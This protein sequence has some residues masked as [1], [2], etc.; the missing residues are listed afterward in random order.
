MFL[1]FDWWT[2]GVS[3]FR[4]GLTQSAQESKGHATSFKLGDILVKIGKTNVLGYNLRELRQLVRKIPTGTQLQIIVYR[5]YKEISDHW[6]AAARALSTQSVQLSSEEG[7]F[8]LSSSSTD[9]DDQTPRARFKNFRPLSLFWHDR[10]ISIPPV[11]RTWH[12]SRKNRNVLI[13][14]SHVDC[15]IVL[16]RKFEDDQVVDEG[17]VEAAPLYAPWLE[18]PDTVSSSSSSSSSSDLQWIR[19]LQSSDFNLPQGDTQHE[20]TTGKSAHVVPGQSQLQ[21]LAME[22]GE[23]SSISTLDPESATLPSIEFFLQHFHSV[24][25]GTYAQSTDTHSSVVTSGDPET[26]SSNLDTTLEEHHFSHH[27]SAVD[28]TT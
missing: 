3:E 16:H 23:Q 5:N 22:M 4:L 28:V 27:G 1:L 20:R 13:V 17:E 8:S 11:S 7:E 14:G 19:E 24:S 9:D 12:A 10:S 21:P 6:R 26:D 18:Q 2:A 15:D 25:S